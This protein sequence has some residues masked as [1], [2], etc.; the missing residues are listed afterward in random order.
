M[1]REYEIF[2]DLLNKNIIIDSEKHL[3]YKWDEEKMKKII[4]G[5]AKHFDSDY[6]IRILP[7][8]YKHIQSI[9]GNKILR[10]MEE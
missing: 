3:H 10:L 7:D 1:I 6:I 8:D 9:I 2:D 5:R 4:I